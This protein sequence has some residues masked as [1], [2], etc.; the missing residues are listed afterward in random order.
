MSLPLNVTA[1]TFLD[2]FC[3]L[4]PHFISTTIHIKTVLS[5]LTLLSDKL[6]RW[7]LENICN[8]VQSGYTGGC[9]S[10]LLLLELLL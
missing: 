6:D 1:V 5:Q 9:K 7:S 10:N 4:W 2:D 3:G 8:L